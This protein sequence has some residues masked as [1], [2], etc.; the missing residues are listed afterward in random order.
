MTCQPTKCTDVPA[1]A[2]RTTV[3]ATSLGNCAACKSF[4]YGRSTLVAEL[5]SLRC[6]VI[7]LR[8]N[9]GEPLPLRESRHRRGRRD[10]RISRERER[11]PAG[12]RDACSPA[13][14]LR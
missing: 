3:A 12:G 8:C 4:G 6:R 7:A 10:G 5:R 13:L 14:L 1:A 11:G 9:P 2:V